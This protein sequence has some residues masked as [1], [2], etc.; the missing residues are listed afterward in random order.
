MNFFAT[1]KRASSGQGSNQFIVQQFTRA[2][3][4][5]SLFLKAS[6]TGDKHNTIDKLSLIFE[7]KYLYQS[8]IPNQSV[9]SYNSLIISSFSSDS[10]KLGTSPELNTLLTS[11]KNISFVIWLS[12]ISN[13]V[14]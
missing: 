1:D 5:L 6:P 7:I 12:F 14:C 9:S 8:S 2:G 13:V 3:N 4:I 10:H 11:S